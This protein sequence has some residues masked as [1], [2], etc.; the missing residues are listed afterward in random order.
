MVFMVF[1]Q[2]GAAA[3]WGF[4]TCAGAPEDWKDTATVTGCGAVYHPP[5][6]THPGRGD[7]GLSDITF[8]EQS[9]MK[10]NL[11]RLSGRI[12]LPAPDPGEV[13]R[14]E[15]SLQR[16]SSLSLLLLHLLLLLSAPPQIIVVL[17]DG[18]E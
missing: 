2:I 11:L 12:R 17:S 3:F 6:Q 5:P 18:G 1:M 10:R 13:S 7:R 16:D 8:Q 4:H 14:A 9:A 15:Q